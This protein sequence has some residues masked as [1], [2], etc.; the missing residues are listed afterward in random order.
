MYSQYSKYF[1]KRCNAA[2]P[3]RGEPS[4]DHAE[5]TAAMYRVR[6]LRKQVSDQYK[7]HVMLNNT[8]QTGRRPGNAEGKRNV[9]GEMKTIS[10]SPLH[11]TDRR[12][13]SHRGRYSRHENVTI[14]IRYDSTG[15][16]TF[17]PNREHTAFRNQENVQ[18][19][20]I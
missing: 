11:E 5:Q 10:L 14:I 3:F 12:S 1:R 19:T 2:W 9:T 6:G 17:V 7:T 18:K 13:S 15:R 20:D 8:V 4:S 16:L